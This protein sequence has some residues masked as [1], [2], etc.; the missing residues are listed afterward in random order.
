MRVLAKSQNK[1]GVEPATMTEH[2]Q[3]QMCLYLIEAEFHFAGDGI[4][5]NPMQSADF[6][7]SDVHETEL[8]MLG[9]YKT[10]KVAARPK[11]MA[12]REEA[13]ADGFM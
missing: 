12:Y 9:D 4:W 8:E 10:K 2:Q 7:G 3:L 13:V 11:R 6:A 5:L 1:F